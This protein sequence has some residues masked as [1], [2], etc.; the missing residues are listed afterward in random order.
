LCD[1]SLGEAA[2]G[3]A[4]DSEVDTAAIAEAADTIDSGDERK[5]AGAAV[6]R[7]IGQGSH[8][9][10]QA[11]GQDMD[12]DFTFGRNRIWEG[13]KPGRLI[14]RVYDGCIHERSPLGGQLVGL[15]ISKSIPDSTRIH[16]CALVGFF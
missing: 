11:R 3:A 13:G 14:E 15:D 12:Q 7:A 4:R 16:N 2:E 9:R 5:Y 6:V 1:R 10:V 8:D